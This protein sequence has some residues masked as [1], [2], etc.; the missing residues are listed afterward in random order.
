M[1][2]G[3]FSGAGICP[4]VIDGWEVSDLLYFWELHRKTVEDVRREIDKQKESF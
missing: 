4:S 1:A 2:Q 3:D